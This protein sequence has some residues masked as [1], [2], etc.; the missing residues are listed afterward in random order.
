[1]VPNARPT[2][3]RDPL[4]G[5]RRKDGGRQVARKMG[6]IKVCIFCQAPA[7]AEAFRVEETD[8]ARGVERWLSA[9]YHLCSLHMME[10][11]PSPGRCPPP[12]RS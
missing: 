12:G 11:L 10:P 6:V 7:E 4:R 2:H 8:T 9:V 3:G 5:R 1:M